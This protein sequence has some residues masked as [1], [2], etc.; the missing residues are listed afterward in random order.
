MFSTAD[1]VAIFKFLQLA[2][3]AL[4]IS[5]IVLGSQTFVR[6]ADDAKPFPTTEVTT[7]SLPS[8]IAIDG[9][10]ASSTVLSFNLTL[11]SVSL[12]CVNVKIELSDAA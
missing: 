12:V 6:F 3:A 8:I 4:P 5:L 9:I 11:H 10:I 2:N 7:Y 1:N